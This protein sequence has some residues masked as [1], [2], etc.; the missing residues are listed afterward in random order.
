[1]RPI[2][3][4]LLLISV[5]PVVAQQTIKTLHPSDVQPL[6]LS[7]AGEKQFDEDI[8]M[9]E[10]VFKKIKAGT[11]VNDLTAKEKELY[12]SGMEAEQGYW[13]AIGGGCSWYCGGGPK[14]IRASSALNGQGDNTYGAG[15][16]HD[17][18]FKTAWVEGVSGYGIG[19]Y[20]EYEFEGASPRINT[21]IVA[22]GYVKSQT[23]WENNSRVK[24]LKVYLDD[25]PLFILALQ[26]KRAIQTFNIDPIGLSDRANGAAWQ[27]LSPWKLKFEI[28]EVYKGLKYD[29][30]AIS[31]IYFDGLDVHCL[32]KGTKITMHN[33]TLKKIEEIMEGDNVLSLIENSGELKPVRVEGVAKAIH[34]QLVKYTFENG[35]KII[36]TRDHPFLLHQKGWASFHPRGSQQY[37]GFQN[38]AQIQINDE[39]YLTTADGSRIITRLINIETLPGHHETYTITRLSSGKNFIANGLVVGTEEVSMIAKNR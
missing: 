28:L 27:N 32:A 11:K 3:F 5:T 20:L 13:D 12:E 18:S 6:E 15:N 25:K 4:C 1:M 26:D 34:H 24:K 33:G 10:A 30:V 22:N 8:R 39:F 31:E 14:E 9:A 7:A 16:A 17:L 29:D 21:I 23:A 35:A 19:Q 2:I 38:I 37:N 36:A